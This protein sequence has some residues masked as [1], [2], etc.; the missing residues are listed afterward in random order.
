MSEINLKDF[1]SIAKETIYQAGEF[2]LQ[3]QNKVQD[4]GKEETFAGDDTELLKKKRSA[5]TIIDI[6]VQEQL[7]QKISQ[8]FDTS[9]IYLDAEEESRYKEKFS[10]DNQSKY[11]LIVDPIDST[12]GYLLGQDYFSINLGLVSQEKVLAA[13]VYYPKRKQLYYL[14]E[15]SVPSLEKNQVKETLISKNDQSLVIFKNHRI[16]DEIVSLLE[17]RGYTIDSDPQDEYGEALL[18]C[19]HGQYRACI[20]HTPQIRDVL[21]GAI[22]EKMENGFAINNQ[23]EKLIWLNG[24]RLPLAIFGFKKESLNL[25]F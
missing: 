4:L 21:L 2:T 19:I 18:K 12:L 6:Q 7:I 1:I 13:F 8:S 11:T 24:G 3:N 17:S 22:I 10:T 15:N 23:E 20:F 14:D 25:K 9:D 5:K 16:S